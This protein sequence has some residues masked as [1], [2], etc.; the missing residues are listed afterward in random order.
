GLGDAGPR[1]RRARP[2]HR[3]ALSRLRLSLPAPAR[4]RRAPGRVLSRPLSAASGA[5]AA[6]AVQGIGGPPASR[7][8]G[9]RHR[10][11]LRGLSRPARLP[12]DEG[13]WAANDSPASVELPAV[14]RRGPL[15]RRRL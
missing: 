6:D 15:P 3:R 5:V 9:A 2:L 10:S 12:P 7:A 1:L 4:A 8:L 11:R 13:P 14:G